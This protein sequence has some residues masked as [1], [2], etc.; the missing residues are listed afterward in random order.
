[1]KNLDSK[2]FSKGFIPKEEDELTL[3]ENGKDVGFS[4]LRNYP[5][6]GRFYPAKTK[7]GKD[8]SVGL[9]RLA[10]FPEKN[11]EK[12][13]YPIWADVNLFSRYLRNKF[14][15]SFE[16]DDCPT[17]ESL[18]I[19]KKS[20]KPLNIEAEGE[21]FYDPE[22]EKIKDK[23]GRE[24][25]WNDVID[26][27]FNV[28]LRTISAIRGSWISLKIFSKQC[29]GKSIIFVERKMR[30]FFLEWY[31]GMTLA[32]ALNTS[33]MESFHQHIPQGSYRV[34]NDGG[35]SFLGLKI[36]ISIPFVVS[37]AFLVLGGFIFFENF[38]KKNLNNAL[39][40][41]ALGV[42]WWWIWYLVIPYIVIG[43]SN[44]FR[45]IIRGLLF[46]KTKV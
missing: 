22:T 35:F 30:S 10:I 14:D 28:H 15:Y 43:L 42:L 40:I 44:M 17:E 46:G 37:S 31:L 27:L 4:I 45:W 8:D 36:K 12:N 33:M 11:K 25:T 41:A 34:L 21:F 9:I 16:D 20:K 32:E 23:K 5:K 18:S 3:F 1:M 29:L 19:S 7:E 6:G 24:K 26:Y 13:G 2:L 38:F 39:L